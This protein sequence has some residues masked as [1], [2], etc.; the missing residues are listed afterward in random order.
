MR[1]LAWFG[2]LVVV[3]LL[4]RAWF[5]TGIGT[6]ILIAAAVV[7]GI[8]LRPDLQAA[9]RALERAPGLQGFW[10]LPA[11]L[12]RPTRKALGIIAPFVVAF[13]INGWI[14]TLWGGFGFLVALTQ[15][16]INVV[17]ADLFLR[18]VPAEAHR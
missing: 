1:A 14:S 11:G 16:A 7:L 15:I 13:L 9:L 17:V 6:L 10:R 4:G 8:R 18:D 5:S 3:A 12:P 2:G